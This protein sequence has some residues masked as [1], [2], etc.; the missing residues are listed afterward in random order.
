MTLA[1]NRS[2]LVGGFVLGGLVLAVAAVLLFGG[3]SLFT[4]KTEA[5]AFFEGSIAGLQ[6]GAPVTFRGVRVGAVRS[7]E[8]RLDLHGLT[9]AIPV[10]LDLEPDNVQATNGTSTGETVTVQQL[11]AAGLRARLTTQ[12]LVTGQ[13]TVE[14]DLQPGTPA[15]LNGGGGKVPEIPA[16]PSELQKLRDQVSEL[17]LRELADT[18]GRTLRAIETLSG[19]LNTS[20][21]PTLDSLHATS[22]AAT[23]A[24]VTSN[25]AIQVLQ[26]DLDR[27]MRNADGVIAEAQR[28]L[29]SGGADLH[30]TLASANRAADQA[31][32]LMSTVNSL[33]DPRSRMRADLEA[34]LRDLAASASSLRSLASELERNPSAI[35]TGRS[36]R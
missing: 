32:T 2:T 1:T 15:H 5:V 16:L 9:T 13:L 14:L 29:A 8:L 21:G 10:Y 33:A 4:A 3:M 24:L 27:T 20:V 28:Q 22:D 35:L 19:K 30:R 23:A 36:A 17:P 12:S 18:A 7:I 31:A 25:Q 34:T 6:I 11:I 26:A